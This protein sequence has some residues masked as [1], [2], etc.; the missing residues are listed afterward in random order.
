M[1]ILSYSFQQRLAIIAKQS[2]LLE[3][4]GRGVER[5]ALRVGSRGE[6]SEKSHPYA[7]GSALTHELITMDYAESLIE[8]ITPVAKNV[9]QLFAYLNDIHHYVAT[10]LDEH[11]M[12]WPLSMPC[13][14]T[15]E[16]DIKI[17]QFGKSNI[18]MMKTIYR[19]GLKNRYGSMM[20]MIAGVHYNFSFPQKFWAL[21]KTIHQS[22]LTGKALQSAGYL[23]LTRNY[24][25]YG[26]VI[27]YLFGASAT[28]CK[29]FLHKGR[30]TKLNFEKM[31]DDMVG[32]PYA[33]SLR[34]SDLGYTSAAQAG[35]KINYNTLAGYCSSVRSILHKKIA[36]FES[37]G[38]KVDGKYNQLNDNI[39][40]IENELYSSIRP[41]RVQKK[42]ETPLQAL[43]DHGIEYME[44]R[45]LDVNPFSN[46]G[47][48]KQQVNFIDLFLIWSAIKGSAP[49]S[50]AE[51]S[52]FKSNFND[53]VTDGRNPQLTLEIDGQTKSVAQWGAWMITELKE[54]A[55]ILDKN[56]DC[57][58]SAI[59]NMAAQFE[60]PN[61]T[62]SARILADFKDKIPEHESLGSHLS[63]EYKQQLI[64]FPYSIYS[65]EY[66][67]NA[68]KTSIE[69][70]QQIEKN[71]TQNLD[72]FLSEYFLNA[73]KLSAER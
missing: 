51:V 69:K 40:Q 7:F 1:H 33:T 37:I 34:M 5:E 73:K 23:G 68:R 10:K 21:W 11:E 70:R 47:L 44:I 49:L 14:V 26:W 46:V 2:D 71:D 13:F 66:F 58:G 24:L 19:Q 52:H 65:A 3:G 35:L 6:L 55:V 64:D 53:I 36:K 25:R 32:V 30:E 60:D 29:S 50:D 72:E 20:Q 28:I 38:I 4:I 12:L 59:N 22:N 56:T 39:L 15:R 63:R 41:K 27:P 54:L 31:G 57:Y 16:E 48:T 18:G 9:D 43:N 45:S 62:T 67:E 61:L 8:L 17:A 42:G